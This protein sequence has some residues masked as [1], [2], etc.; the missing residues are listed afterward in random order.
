M[1]EKSAKIVEKSTKNSCF[2][3]RKLNEIATFW[4]KSIAYDR[5]CV[6]KYIHGK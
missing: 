6:L 5:F 1:V 3:V 4:V 2:V